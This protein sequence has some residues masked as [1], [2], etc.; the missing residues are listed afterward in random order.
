[1]VVRTGRAYNI[2]MLA[3]QDLEG[4]LCVTCS[5][6]LAHAHVADARISRSPGRSA[7]HML[8]CIGPCL[9]EYADTFQ[10][11]CARTRSNGPGSC[12]YAA[13]QGL[14]CLLCNSC[15]GADA[16]SVRRPSLFGA[17]VTSPKRDINILASR[18]AA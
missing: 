9:R 1:M 18:R 5:Y 2:Q 11:A 3:D 10:G 6:V 4:R 16:L 17:V 8:L 15:S 12:A 14:W 13:L 7:Q